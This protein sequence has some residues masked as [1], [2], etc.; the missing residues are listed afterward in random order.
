MAR[1]AASYLQQAF[2]WEAA[3][4]SAY[5]VRAQV[6]DRVL[7]RDLGFFEGKD[8]V[9]AGDVAYRITT[10]ASDV[11]DTM[12]AI[13][14][15]VVPNTLQLVAMSTQ[16]VKIS[17][18]LSLMSALVIP[19]MSL[20]IA[21]LGEALRKISNE[22]NISVAKLS[23]YLNE[24]LP[25]MIVVKANNL[26]LN[27]SVRFQRLALDDMVQR[28][29]KRKM[30]ALI[31]QIV[32][33]V[34][35]GGA[36]VLCAG[37]LLVSKNPCDSSKYLS[38]IMSLA[39]LVEP[40]QSVGKAYDELKQGEPAVERLFDL[41]RFTSKVIEKPDAVDL[42]DVAGDIKFCG[43]TF[44]YKDDMPCVLDR[45][46]LHIRSGESV[47]LIGPSGG[48]KTTL[49]KLLLRL[50]DP[51]SGR[52]LVDGHDI[53]DVTLRSLRENIVLVSQDI[54]LF[55]GTIAE[56]I[57]Y[58]DL[59]G[60]IDRERVEYASRVA[61]ADEFIRALSE[62]YETNIGPRGSLLSGGQRQRIAIARALYQNSSIL[63]LDEATSAL[64]SRSELLV[65]QALERL[66]ANHTVLVI[67]HRPETVLMADR[68]LL[69]NKG[70]LEEVSKSEFLSQD[71][72]YNSMANSK[73]II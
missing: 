32:Q 43:I 61:N 52:I 3:L 50:Y 66:M 16:M 44:K 21:Y 28:L 39:L 7:Q 65:R 37:S 4:R 29:K 40:I 15:T 10:E 38:F 63:I 17:P 20:V 24:V 14:N 59:I 1:C 31:P 54:M 6:F 47:A 5:R 49:T 11:A 41:T 12:Y 70:K 60:T 26:E 56:N 23:A 45:L 30:K 58:G 22:A 69:L 72:S 25:S 71:G 8:G 18:S 13:L 64:D 33:I 67:A 42:T 36:L 73:I 19:V 57:G 27:E 62:G 55:S 48:G 2:L 34:C 51:S 68:V 46:D 9:P 53:Q 35:I